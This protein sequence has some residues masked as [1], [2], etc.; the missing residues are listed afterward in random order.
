MQIPLVSC[1]LPVFEGLKYLAAL[2]RTFNLYTE[3]L[4]IAGRSCVSAEFM[5][6]LVLIQSEGLK[7]EPLLWWFWSGCGKNL[8]SDDELLLFLGR[9]AHGFV[10]WVMDD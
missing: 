4:F 2:L 1:S 8:R 7:K 3:L 9:V 6:G 10:F 5:R